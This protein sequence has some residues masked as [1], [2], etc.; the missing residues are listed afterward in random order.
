MRNIELQARESRQLPTY[1]PGDVQN[2]QLQGT[3]PGRGWAPQMASDAPVGLN[4]LVNNNISTN[5]FDIEMADNGTF[6]QSSS[7]GLTPG[8]STTYPSNSST[9]SPPQ[10][11]EEAPPNLKPVPSCHAFSASGDQ[12]YNSSSLMDAK[13][14]N[15]P[16]VNAQEDVFKVPSSWGMTDGATQ[17]LQAFT[18]N[19]DWD[20]M[21][22]EAGMSWDPQQ[23]SGLTP[24]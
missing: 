19:A 12:S 10:V 23:R 11:E 8:S 24:R 2:A 4:P 13:S 20:K 3:S 22:Q 7:T 9:Y 14:P 6:A 18:P 17:N 1:Y 21:M 5:G 16:T 15:M